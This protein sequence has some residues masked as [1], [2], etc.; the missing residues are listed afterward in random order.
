MSMEIRYIVLNETSS[1]G[2]NYYPLYKTNNLRLR[3]INCKHALF[4]TFLFV[5]MWN[6][7]ERGV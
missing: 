4:K 6:E 1:L 5:Y 2:L 7:I 3:C